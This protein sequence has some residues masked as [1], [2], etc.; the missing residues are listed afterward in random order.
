MKLQPS[1]ARQSQVQGEAQSRAAPL[2]ARG[3][4]W[5]LGGGWE[6]GVGGWSMQV[7]Q[8]QLEDVKVKKG[9]ASSCQVLPDSLCVSLHMQHPCAQRTAGG[10]WFC[11]S[12]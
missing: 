10:A 3:R 2:G 6:G 4:A 9:R 7:T 5:G 11:Q 8:I 1:A 12:C